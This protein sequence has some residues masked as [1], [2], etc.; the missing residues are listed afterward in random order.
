MSKVAIGW[1]LPPALEFPFL[2]WAVTTLRSRFWPENLLG[3]FGS[4]WSCSFGSRQ[5]S[6]PADRVLNCGYQWTE[7]RSPSAL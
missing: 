6:E 4:I 3:L 5:F 7:N 2:T 1:N